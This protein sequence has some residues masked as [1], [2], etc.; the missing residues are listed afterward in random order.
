MAFIGGIIASRA[1]NMNTLVGANVLLGLSGGVHTCYGLTVGEICPNKYK[2]LGVV[3][4][5]LPSCTSTGFGAYIAIAISRNYSWRYLYYIFLAMMGLAIIL[6]ILFY[7]PPTFKQLHG[8]DRTPMDELKRIDWIGAILLTTGLTLFL[9]GVSWGGSPLPWTSSRILGLL[10]T[11]GIVLFIMFPIW[12][13][14][15]KTPNALIPMHF[16]KDV[17]G[18]VMM[19]IIGSV[20]GTVYVATAIIW[21]SQVAAIYASS[22]T[23]WQEKAWASTTIAFGIWGGIVI[24]GPL[25][26]I[27]KH[28]R[29][30]LIVMMGVS[31][32]FMGALASCNAG[33]F[34][35]SA[36]F[37]FLATFPAGIL[38]IMSVLLVQMDSN[39]ADLG[40]VL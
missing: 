11:G 30:Q 29:I 9:L 38:E 36:A 37:S 32:A 15:S 2:F 35:R 40:T 39:D 1:Q 18:F 7:R 22:I 4:C 28:V 3:F 23:N 16:F 12:E 27:I 21:P 8:D 25:V 31:V 33:N 6:Q 20:S 26:S 19:V 13:I 24:L 10:I 34:G 5:V 17:R 14:Y